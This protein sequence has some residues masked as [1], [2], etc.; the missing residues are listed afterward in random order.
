MLMDKPLVLR[1]KVMA[2]ITAYHD[3]Y[4]ILGHSHYRRTSVL[5]YRTMEDLLLQVISIGKIYATRVHR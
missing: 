3:Q 4:Q 5:N 2:A 1:V